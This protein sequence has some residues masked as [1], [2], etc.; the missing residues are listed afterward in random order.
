LSFVAGIGPQLAKNLVEFR[1]T[2]GLFQDRDQLTKVPRFSSK[3][4]E[5]CAG[6]LRVMNGKQILDKTGIHPERYQAVR[7]MAGELSVPV[8]ELIGEGAKKLLQ[9]RTK[10]TALVGEFTFE[11]IIR[12]LEKPGRDPRDSFKV[13]SFRD[14]IFEM[15]D[16][17]EAMICPGIVTNVTN[18]GAFVDIGVHQDGLVHISALSHK[19]V[20][21]PRK[22]VNPGDQVRVKVLAVDQEKKQISLSMLLDDKPARELRPE[23]EPRPERRPRREGG[24][25]RAPRS[26][27]GARGGRP[28]AAR[29][30]PASGGP[31][32]AQGRPGEGEQRP[33]RPPR[34]DGDRGPR[35]GGD[36]PQGDRG[37]RPA[38]K[39][40]N[41]PFAAWM[42][43]QGDGKTDRTQKPNRK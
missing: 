36:R 17:K 42:G 12:E 31:R 3:S 2:N 18:F 26:E 29:A 38:G 41:N 7:D 19:F 15:K 23:G 27:E 10:W 39:P 6:F 22:V 43:V 24:E 20:D 40:F 1:Q 21:D 30:R 34:R 35:H 9:L 13:F 37:P 28:A 16:L 4:F 14:D 33:P 11:D 8:S 25:Q 5:Q 32:P